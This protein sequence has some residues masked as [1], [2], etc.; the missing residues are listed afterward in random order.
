MDPTVTM[1]YCSTSDFPQ[2]ENVI[3][4]WD[5]VEAVGSL[6]TKEEKKG[7][8]VVFI[9]FTDEEAATRARAL[10][11]SVPGLSLK[12]NEPKEKQGSAST[13]QK[14]KIRDVT[15]EFLDFTV[16]DKNVTRSY[17]ARKNTNANHRVPGNEKVNRQNNS[18]PNI[19]K[20]RDNTG[21]SYRHIAVP[22]AQASVI[23][24]DNVPFNMTNEQVIELFLPYGPIV[25]MN[26]YETMVMIFYRSYKSVLDCIQHLNGKVIKGNVIT[27]SSGTV[28]VPRPVALHMGI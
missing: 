22:H 18:G 13:S 23:F 10:I 21:D 27:V 26:R 1:A 7:M 16:Q 28:K 15:L 24:V 12:T 19:H 20:R 17:R 25:D 6:R 9:K 14:R 3:R 11:T 8:T 4:E 5:G 2:V